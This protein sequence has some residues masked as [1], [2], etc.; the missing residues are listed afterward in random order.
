[1][2]Q[3]LERNE[4]NLGWRQ[5]AIVGADGKGAVFNGAKITS[6]L[7]AKVGTNCAAAGNI[8]RNSGVV[9]AMVASF[10]ENEDQPLAEH[11]CERSK[12]ATLPAAN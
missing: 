4:P 8:L 6:V 10:E 5:L 2:V 7:K 1:M 3:D 12:P 9:D 11:S